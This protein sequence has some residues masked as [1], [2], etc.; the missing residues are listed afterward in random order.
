MATKRVR[1]GMND[2]VASAGLS[3]IFQNRTEHEKRIAEKLKREFGPM[4]CGLL[5]EDHRVIEIM[6]NPDGVLGSND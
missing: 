6:L 3:S 5:L 2:L 4:V 1:N